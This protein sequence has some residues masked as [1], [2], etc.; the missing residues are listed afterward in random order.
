MD[1]N[2]ADLVRD[3]AV[4]AIPLILALTWAEAARGFMANRLGDRTPKSAGRLT[5]N[6]SS[7]IDP[8]FTVVV[9]VI[10]FFL[11]GGKW[12]VGGAKQIPVN[13][14]S[15]KHPH[16]GMGLVSFASILANFAMAFVW[17]LLLL[18][19]SMT[20]APENFFAQMAQRGVM[21]NLVFLAFSLLPIPPFTGWQIA[22]A[23][24]SDSMA[25]KMQTFEQQFSM[26]SLFIILAMGSTIFTYW[27]EPIMSS[28]YKLLLLLVT[29]L[30][31]VLQAIL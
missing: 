10:S 22:K 3:L 25:Y 2:F 28:L 31:A 7:H 26:F 6:P 1:F 14:S 18:V 24:V 30:A 11:S 20:V 15:F 23:M 8:M 12:L 4:A 21:V 5:L 16:I 27:I 13:A 29:P 9:P 19:L 17:L